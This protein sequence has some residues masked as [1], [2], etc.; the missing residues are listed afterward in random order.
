M[1]DII[2]P[3]SWDEQKKTET[4]ATVIANGHLPELMGAERK[5][6]K[7]VDI[8][9]EYCQACGKWHIIGE[10]TAPK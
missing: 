2:F 10:H 3:W 1:E 7:P 9:K 6:P 8:N 5:T 4:M